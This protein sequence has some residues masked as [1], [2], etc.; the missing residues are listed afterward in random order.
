MH[1]ARKS[2]LNILVDGHAGAAVCPVRVD[3]GIS[4]TLVFVG[5]RVAD[6]AS[7]AH[8][9]LRVEQ[10]P[11]A[12]SHARVTGVVLMVG[13]VVAAHRFLGSDAVQDLSTAC[14]LGRSVGDRA[15]AF[16]LFPVFRLT[17]VLQAGLRIKVGGQRTRIF[18]V[19]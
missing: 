2:K 5:L 6:F 13:G 3:Q 16:Q 10:L 15:A 4:T 7:T 9:R 8:L 18:S 12:L 11:S 19:S 1:H 14:L 17:L